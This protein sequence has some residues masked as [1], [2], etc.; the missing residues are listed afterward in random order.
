M[1]NLTAAV[2]L[3]RSSRTNKISRRCATRTQKLAILRT[4]QLIAAWRWNENPS[5]IDFSRVAANTK[6]S[7]VVWSGW[8]GPRLMTIRKQRRLRRHGCHFH[9][10]RH[11]EMIS[12]R[13]R[14]QIRQRP[15]LEIRVA[16][17]RRSERWSRWCP[18]RRWRWR[19]ATADGCRAANSIGDHAINGRFSI[20]LWCRQIR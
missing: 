17:K 11:S 4:N 8:S 12:L 18:R 6:C 20:G 10:Q 7:G 3:A 19:S 13:R 16:S 1:R 14:R 15:R 9:D 5:G 2:N